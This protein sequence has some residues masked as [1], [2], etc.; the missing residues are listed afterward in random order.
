MPTSYHGAANPCSGE[1]ARLTNRVLA[2]IYEPGRAAEALKRTC[3]EIGPLSCVRCGAIAEGRA[4]DLQARLDDLSVR[5]DALERALDR[6]AAPPVRL[7]PNLA[8][9]Y[10]RKVEQLHAGLA[11]PTIRDEA[12]AIFRKGRLGRSGGSFGKAGCGGRI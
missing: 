3:V 5:R 8:Q 9:V 10:R 12:V 7:H 1:E 6:D 2:A 11:E 4:S